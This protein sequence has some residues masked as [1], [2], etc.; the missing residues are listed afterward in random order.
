MNA[1]DLDFETI[2]PIDFNNEALEPGS[3]PTPFSAFLYAGLLS[4]ARP[5]C[6]N[7]LKIESALSTTT[8]AREKSAVSTPAT[9]EA[10]LL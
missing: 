4:A 5:A 6:L 1:H 2:R 8:P 3:R 10:F 7:V 9:N